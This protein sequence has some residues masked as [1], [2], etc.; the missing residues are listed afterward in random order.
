[1][2]YTYEKT[3]DKGLEQ[4]AVQ[5]TLDYQQPDEKQPQAGLPFKIKSAKLKSKNPTGVVLFDNK[6]G[7]V[8]SSEMK[9][10]LEGDLTIEIGGQTTTVNLSQEQTST[11]ETSDEDPTQKKKG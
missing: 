8:Q 3:T 11:T 5:T 6:K 1:Y 9:L 7:R 10:K 2:N 4:I